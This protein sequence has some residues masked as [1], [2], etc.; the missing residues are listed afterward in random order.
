MSWIEWND[1][2]SVGVEKIDNQ[3]KT[4]INILNL[5]YDS[6][7]EGKEN[8]AIELIIDEL[9]DYTKY[10]FSDEENY[11]K[12]LKYH[13]IEQHI[14]AHKGFIKK[15][16]KFQDDFKNRKEINI[17]ELLD[18]LKDWLINHIMK[19]DQSYGQYFIE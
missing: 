1:A 17:S 12:K 18:F 9:V 8:V 6:I 5:L 4:L 7:N 2:L 10:H 16:K 14:K 19:D 11:F 15:I 3:H 13:N